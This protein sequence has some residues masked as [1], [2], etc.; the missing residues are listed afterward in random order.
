[1]KR[2]LMQPMNPSAALS[3]GDDLGTSSCSFHTISLFDR[4][5]VSL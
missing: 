1:M 3:G 5:V 4:T 2:T